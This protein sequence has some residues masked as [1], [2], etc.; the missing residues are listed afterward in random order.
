MTKKKYSA[1]EFAMRYLTQYPKSERDMEVILLQKKYTEKEIEVAIY[2]LKQAGLLDDAH[3]VKL[4]I[5][6]EVIK[7]W[8]P[9]SAVKTLLFKKGI[10]KHIVEKYCADN[11]KDIRDGIFQR[12]ELEIE[13]YKAK[14]F[15]WIEIIQKLQ[16]RGYLFG[17]IQEA[18]NRRRD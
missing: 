2:K 18:V 6:S 15:V 9:I 14:W 10:E 1:I 3:Y 13:K 5:D 4:Y 16:Q 8:K 17:H 7:K 11:W 12:I